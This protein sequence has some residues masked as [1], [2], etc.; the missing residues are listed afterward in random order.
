METAVRDRGEKE[1]RERASESDKNS[2]QSRCCRPSDSEAINAHYLTDLPA[3]SLTD[4]LRV[5]VCV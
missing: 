4:N 5:R 1:G 3:D 2:V